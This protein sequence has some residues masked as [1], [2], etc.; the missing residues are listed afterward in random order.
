MSASSVESLHDELRQDLLPWLLLPMAVVGFLLALLDITYAPPPS[1][2][3]LGFL[4]LFLAGALWWARHKDTNTITWA[5]ILTMVFVVV[6]AW[7]WLPV[8]GLRYALVLPVI[9]AGISRGPRGAVVI[10]A[11]SVL[12]LFADAWQVGLRE[13]SN[14]L[15]GSAATLAVATYLAY[16]SER[17]QRATLGW[18]WNRYE[19][20][21]HALDDARDRQAEL[22]QALND[23]ALAQ[24][25]STRLNNL[26]TASRAALEDASRA[27]EKFVANVSHELRTPLNMIIGF[28]D[29]ILTRPETYAA[30]LPPDL[31][32]DVA[33]IKRNSE[34]LARLVDDVLDLAETETGHMRLMR[35]DVC[36]RDLLIEAAEAVALLFEKK[37]LQLTLDVPEELPCVYCDRVRIRQVVLNLLSN[38]GR[39][40]EEG[41]VT[42]RAVVEQ[43][44]ITVSVA[45]TGPGLEPQKRER[46]FQPFEQGDPSIRRQV[47]G[48]GLGLA[49]SK[50]LVEMHGGRIWMEG[51]LGKG[52]TVKFSLPLQER[53]LKRDVRTWF[54]IYH[55]YTPRSQ[56]SLAPKPEAKPGLAIVERGNT[57]QQLVAR[58]LDDLDPVIVHS[59]VQVREM[60][61]LGVVAGVLV[62][63]NNCPDPTS[64]SELAGAAF[65]VPIISC[66][67]PEESDGPQGPG[68][69]DYLVKP[70]LHSKVLASLDRIAPDARLVLV[71][72]D[73]PEARQLFSR[74]LTR[75]GRQ[76]LTAADGE[77]ALHLLR[78]RRPDL[79]LLDM[80]MPHRDGFAVLQEKAADPE[81][82][83]IPVIV[84][85]ARD[86]ER[87]PI[88]SKSLTVTRQ[89]GLSA[90]D[91][92][93]GV[94]AI[95]TALGPRFG[96][97]AQ[98]GTGGPSQASG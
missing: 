68:V 58:Y 79:L 54:N 82:A 28:S 66:W 50:Q 43:D 89:R 91:L 32:E 59:L 46:L 65:D 12:L 3:A 9:V 95:I 90:R 41:G 97:P 83:S 80:V 67:V 35:E 26:L 62:N 29:E 76:V 30:E 81:I 19:H 61:D 52:T 24:R 25:E 70:V 17:G 74:V 1:P 56:R 96:V 8:P 4:M 37:G 42:I 94:Q 5:T 78:D 73:D 55:E 2:T 39:F 48:S 22:R 98:P 63:A 57:L 20:A 14:E 86:P 16:V 45:D 7:H 72:D 87:Q 93:L 84:V 10:G 53:S 31:L 15:L 11:L 40:T 92:V 77:A 71:A 18:A 13:S 85:S 34:H 49:I 88:V 36:I 69:R 44:L 21:R 27:K 64:L 38:A 60:V 51:E 75:S 6:L 23:L 47:G 33:A